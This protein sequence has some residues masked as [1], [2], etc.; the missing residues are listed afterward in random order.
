MG[1]KAWYRSRTIWV[2]GVVVLVVML[3]AVRQEMT[4]TPPQVEVVAV[5]LATLNIVLRLL[6]RQPVGRGR[7][8]RGS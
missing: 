8:R 4:L 7:G 5:A 1:T 2:N 3:T 6:T